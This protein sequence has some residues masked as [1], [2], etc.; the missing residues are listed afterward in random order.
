MCGINS[1]SFENYNPAI[2]KWTMDSA[3]F[4]NVGDM[5]AAAV[6]NRPQKKT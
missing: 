2:N 3:N 5:D 1:M 4:N 6:F